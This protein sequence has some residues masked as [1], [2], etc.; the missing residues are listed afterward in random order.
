MTN[1]VHPDQP[2]TPSTDEV[3]EVWVQHRRTT[4]SLFR[5]ADLEHD[6]FV[7]SV[8]RDA[9][10]DALEEAAWEVVRGAG[11]LSPPRGGQH[12]AVT[13]LRAR[14]AA[15]RRNENEDTRG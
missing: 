15:I 6:R 12:P 3:R 2:Y 8:R 5:E 14:A 4:G 10:A 1:P 7:T 11:L 13:W 9:Q